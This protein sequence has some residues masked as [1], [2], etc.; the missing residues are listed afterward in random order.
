MLKYL[1]AGEGGEKWMESI[2]SDSD[3]ESIYERNRAAAARFTWAP[4]LCNPK[5]DRWLHRI[6]TP[7]HIVWGAE[8]RVLPN[9]YAEALKGQIKDAS[10]TTLPDA[11]H[12]L[13]VEQ[14]AAFAREVAQFIGRHS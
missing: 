6:S 13:H 5:L 8:N 3:L 14:P 12:L 7:T 2:R 4:R 10:L 11:A 1:F 9:A